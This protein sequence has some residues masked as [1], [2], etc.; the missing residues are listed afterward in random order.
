M[1]KKE[2][3]CLSI[4]LL[5][6]SATFDTFVQDYVKLL[7]VTNQVRTVATTIAELLPAE[8]AFVRFFASVKASMN[9]E[10]EIVAEFFLAKF[11]LKRTNICV[12]LLMPT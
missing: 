7:F 9:G 8:R 1:F 3:E 12:N 5:V 4:F 11:T 2:S 6:T 10:V